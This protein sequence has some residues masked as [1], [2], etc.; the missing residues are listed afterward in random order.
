MK[1]DD[2]KDLE[3]VEVTLNFSEFRSAGRVGGVGAK[4]T[5]SV[6]ACLGFAFWVQ[7]RLV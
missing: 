2:E 3:Q 4:T 1:D 5:G 6:R 7:L